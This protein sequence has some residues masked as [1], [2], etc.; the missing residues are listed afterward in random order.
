MTSKR[1]SILVGRITQ[2]VKSSQR[3]RFGQPNRRVS[4]FVVVVNDFNDLALVK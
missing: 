4:S 1:G 3:I 2:C